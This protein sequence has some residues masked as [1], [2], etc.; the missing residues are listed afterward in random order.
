MKVGMDDEDE[1]EEDEEVAHG[2]DLLLLDFKQP[3][4]STE[5]DVVSELKTNLKPVLSKEEARL[6]WDNTL[7]TVPDDYT[8]VITSQGDQF[9]KG[10]QVYL[11]YGRMSNRECLKRYGFCL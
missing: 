2:K 4:R 1:Y 8:F 6:L 5:P 3:A 7:K 10:S 11:C 9:P